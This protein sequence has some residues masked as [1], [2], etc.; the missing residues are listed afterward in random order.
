MRRLSALFC[1]SFVGA[2]PA[3]KT[4]TVSAQYSVVPVLVGPVRVVGGERSARH[5][6]VDELHSRS[7]AYSSGGGGNS[8]A[9]STAVSEMDLNVTIAT[10]DNLDR[11]VLV[12][13]LEC[14]TSGFFLL[15]YLS[16]SVKCDVNGDVLQPVAGVDQA[17]GQ[18]SGSTRP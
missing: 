4:T 1:I 2:A 5:A 3:C 16:Q 10:G 8:F 9:G 17:G 14:R 18:S 11:L 6:K 13:Q 15:F 12:R 7:H